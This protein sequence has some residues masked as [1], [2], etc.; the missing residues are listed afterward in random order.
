MQTN[1]IRKVTE[2]HTASSPPWRARRRNTQ[3][4]QQTV[5]GVN[6]QGLDI[7]N[8]D[9]SLSR[10]QS[11]P[12]E[13]YTCGRP[14]ARLV[15]SRL[16]GRAVRRNVPGL[17]RVWGVFVYGLPRRSTPLPATETLSKTAENRAPETKNAGWTSCTVKSPRFSRLAAVPKLSTPSFPHPVTD[18]GSLP[19]PPRRNQLLRSITRAP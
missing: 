4:R 9:V 6:S 18:V 19:S 11:G 2:V 1:W 3:S 17:N 16:R 7:P 12:S 5:P 15:V 8:L 14:T 13:P 10:S